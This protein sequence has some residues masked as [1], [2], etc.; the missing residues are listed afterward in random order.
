VGIRGFVSAFMCTLIALAMGVGITATV[1][2][3]A[4]AL[5]TSVTDTALTA[6][7][8][9][10]GATEVSVRVSFVATHALATGTD[11]V[12]LDASTGYVFP[13]D[14]AC[15]VYNVTDLNTG[16]DDGCSPLL[17]GAGTNE[18]TIGV[19]NVSA[20]DQV[21]VSVDGVTN[22]SA[23]GSGS[24]SVSTSEDTTPVSMATT[25]TAATPVGQADF[26]TSDSGADYQV[27][28]V[29]TAGLSEPDGA[30]V[31][32]TITLVAAS[33]AIF[34]TD[35]SCSS[36]VVTD[37]TTGVI[38]SC[39]GPVSGIGTN[40]ITM[41]TPNV[42]PGDQVAV[43]IEGVTGSPATPTI[44]LWT[45]SNP[46]HAGPISPDALSGSSLGSLS[47]TTSSP[48]AGA[49][50]VTDQLRFTA[51]QTP[52]G[53]YSITLDAPSGTV[54]PA[55]GNN[56]NYQIDDLTTNQSASGV[57][58][59]GN[60]TNDVV[61]TDNIPYESPA[62][63]I[64]A[65]DQVL[66]TVGG[67]TNPTTAGAGD[68]DVSASFDTTPIAVD[69]ATTSSTAVSNI[70]F[71][72]SSD[73]AG[74]T[75]VTDLIRFTAGEAAT[76][77][78]TITLDAPVGTVFP[79]SGNNDNSY[80][81]ENL[82]TGQSV[83]GGLNYYVVDGAGTNQVVI[84]DVIPYEAGAPFFNPGDQVLLTVNGVTNPS[85]SQQATIA[86][87]SDP[88]PA[89]FGPLVPLAAGVNSPFAFV[90]GPG[91]NLIGPFNLDTDVEGTPFEF[92]AGEPGGIAITP[93]GQTAYVAGPSSG[94]DSITPVNL[95][96]DAVGTP[97]VVGDDVSSLAITPDGS[98]AYAVSGD[99]DTV[100]PV[101]LATHSAET[102]ITVGSD[103]V[104]VAIT[105]D[106][107]TALVVN[108]DDGKVTP[109]DI[110][111]QMAETPIDV[112][113]IP[114]GIA[115]T[116]DGSTAFVVNAG[117][118]S[119][120]P[121]DIATQT[122][123]TPITVG[124]N[125][126]AI[127]ITPDGSTAFVA[128]EGS[129]SVTPIDISSL[130]AGTPIG[131][132]SGPN[133]ISVSPDGTT[134]YVVNEG[135][136]SVTPIGTTSDTPAPSINTVNDPWD[137]A[138]TP[139]QGPTAVLTA[140][141]SG[142]TTSFDASGSATGGSPIVS[143]AW[144]FG[145]GNTATTTTPTETHAYTSTG[146]YTATV[147]ETDAA[148]TSTSQVFTGQTMSNNG[149]AA[150]VASAP[151]VITTTDCSDDTSCSAAI[152]TPATAQTPAQSINV[153][154]AAPGQSSQ[155]LTVTSG[156]GQLN[157]ASKGFSVLEQIASY[158]ATFTPTANVTVTDQLEGVTSTHGVKVCFEGSNNVPELLP[159][160]AR[161][162]PV[163]PCATVA[164]VSDVVEATI[165][166]APGDPRFRIEGVQVLSET[167]SSVA[168]KGVI[169]KTIAIKGTDMLGA[170]GQTLP[171][172]AFT[173][174]NGSTIAGAITK[175]TSKALTVVVPNGA[176][177]GPVALCWPNETA[178]SDGPVAIT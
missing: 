63:P 20:G 48:D 130:T 15:D 65:G 162:S 67:V 119:V 76:G 178:I 94:G 71:T 85:G 95:A 134:A 56:S 133:A 144:N 42:S 14:S 97:I 170:N 4:G 123:G 127:A 58:V 143:Y 164:K 43:T 152:T 163:A 160:C 151:V 6:T 96:T 9:E 75:G 80:L 101:D 147:T 100:V 64:T 146:T 19:P 132:G 125:P 41:R 1:A 161:T 135:S 167:P 145:D 109:I 166:V 40:Q 54:F 108:T 175:S 172:V 89:D 74:A 159:K 105:P 174:V 149:S 45:T 90:T 53:A 116:P 39:T 121:I 2:T 3:P 33:A 103:P 79:A 124:D 113:S 128:N 8:T 77:A 176:A 136:N 81:I 34:P 154:A 52:A 5:G 142:A 104:A 114:E 115:I 87:S 112:G 37:L 18:V 44:K 168:S 36:Y 22:P 122:A 69:D 165:L 11:S 68:L 111:T 118:D 117:S 70:A 86:T 91:P 99:N 137:I 157:C 38:D 107:S 83:G 46:T 78:Y 126:E 84:N 28:F 12:T 140:T 129:D 55:S 59:S 110:A 139:D 21:T 138:I 177:T 24:I 50:E 93:N 26:T 62:P 57:D 92:N 13:A 17:S 27:G 60:G 29:S 158:A 173:S 61:I 102:P 25:I 155:E 23:R 10:V 16:D 169:G 66:V 98:T 148:G 73:V 82:T 153:T 141:T 156:P 7:S 106:G 49:T 32:S 120:T 51:T 131:V 171:T 35:S 72:A 88:T 30:T 31:M 47:F 150:A